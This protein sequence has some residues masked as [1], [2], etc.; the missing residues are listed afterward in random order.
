MSEPDAPDLPPCGIYRTRRAVG[1]IPADRLVYFHNHGDPGPGLYLPSS[2]RGNRA[3]FESRGHLLPEGSAAD[4]LAPLAREG[5]YRVLEPFHCCE[6]RCRRFEPDS[7]VQLGYDAAARSILFVPEW[8]DGQLAIPE[9]GTRVDPERLAALSPLRVPVT[10]TPVH[11][12]GADE[13]L[14]H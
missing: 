6:R 1:S 7:L 10:D 9:R 2:W 3:R 5:F 14:L 8:V 13:V 4:A 12:E 11:D